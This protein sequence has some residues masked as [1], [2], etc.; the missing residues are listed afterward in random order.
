MK[1]KSKTS[2][3]QRLLSA[4]GHLTAV[5]AMVDSDV[6]SEILLF[7]LYAIQGALK[8]IT[9]QMLKEYVDEKLK[10]LVL[11]ESE[12]DNRIALDALLSVY[13]W[14]INRK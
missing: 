2:I 13:S 7:Q 4:G 10:V 12:E 14:S 6:S 8:A 5:T 3:K 1:T 9:N 11:N